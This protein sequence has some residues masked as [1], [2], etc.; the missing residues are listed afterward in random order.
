MRNLT[1]IVCPIGC[2]LSVEEEKTPGKTSAG[3]M[4]EENLSV[5]GNRCLR[6]AVYAREEVRAPKRVVTATCA[7][8][9]G[10]GFLIRRVPVKTSSPCPKEKINALLD[11]IYKTAVKLPVRAGDAVIS[12]WQGGEINVVATRSVTALEK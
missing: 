12:G 9:E 11:D 7:I 3:I 2:Q 4:P 10:G 8:E 5:T 1:C 6:G